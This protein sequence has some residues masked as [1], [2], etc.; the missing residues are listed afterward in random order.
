M[1]IRKLQ[2]DVI[3]HVLL[4]QVGPVQ[5]LQAFV[6]RF[7]ETIWLLEEKL[8]TMET[9]MMAKDV[10]TLVLELQQD[11]NALDHLQYAALCV[12]TESS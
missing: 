4:K 3:S 11:G 10:S 7:V 12:E 9:K 1:E 8:V 5:D 6:P 2:M